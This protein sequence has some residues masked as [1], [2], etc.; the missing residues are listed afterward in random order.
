MIRKV[1]EVGP[2]ICSKCGGG[3]RVAAFLTEHAV[4][5]RII[6]LLKLIIVAAKSRP[7]RLTSPTGRNTVIDMVR[8]RM[9]ADSERAPGPGRKR[10]FLSITLIP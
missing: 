1:Y 2:M 9:Q 7:P 6:D 10:K 8:I 5:A 4:I 3:M